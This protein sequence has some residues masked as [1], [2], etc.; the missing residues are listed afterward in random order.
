MGM[1]FIRITYFFCLKKEFIFICPFSLIFLKVL[2]ND[3]NS[4]FDEDNS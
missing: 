1:I 2:I 3:Y 4:S